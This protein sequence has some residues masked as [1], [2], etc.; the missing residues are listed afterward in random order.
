MSDEVKRL[1]DMIKYQDGVIRSG[2][3][4]LLTTEERELLETAADNHESAN[5]DSGDNVARVLRGLISRLGESDEQ[6]E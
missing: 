2:R 3:V 6:P 1:R 4:A 5:T